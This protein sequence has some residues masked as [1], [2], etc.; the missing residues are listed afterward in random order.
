M[1]VHD[2]P[3]NAGGGAND[4]AAMQFRDFVA[5]LKQCVADGAAL[6]EADGRAGAEA[7]SRK[8]CQLID[9]H[10]MAAGRDGGKA[11][12]DTEP[13]R[14]FLK[15]A[16]ADEVLL[17]TDWSGRA[18]WPHVLLETTLFRSSH[19]GQQ[20]FADIDQLLRE[21]EPAQ[22]PLAQLYLYVLSLGFQG[23]YRDG[24]GHDELAHYRRELFQFAYQRAPD[25][26]A[27]EVVLSEQPYAST[28]SLGAGR[29]RSGLG[30]RGV[31]LA[32]VLLMLL[33][34]SEA[35]WLWQ[36]SPVR[37]ALDVPVASAVAQRAADRP[38]GASC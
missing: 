33:G 34:V 23:R 5:L 3:T 24:A 22:R 1:S 17:H 10:S 15:A 25:M 35:L 20:V 29:R 31:A 21:R 28:L 37:R 12:A 13:Q 11:V 14:R 26:G 27:R 8:L 6:G 36:S 38:W 2:L 9:L 7:F 19:A 16:L 30:L 4:L 32:V 18:A